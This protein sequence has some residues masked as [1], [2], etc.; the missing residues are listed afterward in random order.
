MKIESGAVINILL[1]NPR[2][3]IWGVLH[4]IN[5]TGV[6]VRGLDLNQFEDFVRAVANCETVYGLCE[7]FV[8]LWR[9]E[10]ISRDDADG[11]IPSLQDQ[12]FERTGKRFNEF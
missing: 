3:K 9:V 7:Q 8:P 12:F 2:E 1:Q 6:F 5:Q 4:E 11:D 10:K